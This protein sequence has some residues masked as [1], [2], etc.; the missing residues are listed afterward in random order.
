[1]DRRVRRRLRG[2]QPPPPALVDSDTEGQPPTSVDLDAEDT[3]P[4]TWIDSDA[5]G[6][7]PALVDS[8][9]EDEV[10]Q[11]TALDSSDDCHGTVIETFSDDDSASTLCLGRTYQ[12]ANRMDEELEQAI[13][14]TLRDPGEGKWH[15]FGLSELSFSILLQLRCPPILFNLLFLFNKSMA[16]QNVMNSC[17]VLMSC[18]AW[19][20]STQ[21]SGAMNMLLPSMT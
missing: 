11:V 8:D 19:G 5:K 13:P 2:K 10:L 7:P 16:R 4:D 14:A 12:E 20:E 6:Q 9:K 21:G 17:S 18:V 3:L 15:L 1:M